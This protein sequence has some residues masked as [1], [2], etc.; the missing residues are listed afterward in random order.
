[1]DEQ[2][3]IDNFIDLISDI[4]LKQFKEKYIFVG[5]EVFYEPTKE[6]K[7]SGPQVTS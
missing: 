1:M 5:E 2:E 6:E 4:I 7:N 3:E